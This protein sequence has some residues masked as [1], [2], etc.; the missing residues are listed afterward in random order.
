M[1]NKKISALFSVSI[2]ILSRNGG[3]TFMKCLNGIQ[4]QKID[5][6]YEIIIVDSGS[7]DSTLEEIR[8]YCVRLFQIRPEEFKFG[9]TRDYGFSKAKG[10]IVVTLSQDAIPYDEYW[11]SKLIEP[12]KDSSVAAVQGIEVRPDNS[13]IFF[14]EN[15][16]GFY[17][18]R[19]HIRWLKRYD[20]IG[21]SFVN[22]A[23]RK[24]IWEKYKFGE[25]PMSED[26][27][28]QKKLFENGHKIYVAKSARVYHWHNYD[29]V[30]SVI[31]RCEN[32]GLGWRYAGVNYS[33]MD[34]LFDIL[35]LRKYIILVLGLVSGQVKKLS[36]LLFPLIRPVALYVGN[37]FNTDY[38]S[39]LPKY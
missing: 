23:I 36:E 37:R 30:Q 11:L 32:E 20:E 27:V 12:F 21:L 29:T 15:R 18:T 16:G 10:D 7:T 39:N 34:V 26:K 8:K 5:V 38:K 14:W 1:Q 19:E 35:G 22:A 6:P 9:L 3:K 31:R 13:E 17:F 28:F 24:N 2:V 25:V 4:R 33:I